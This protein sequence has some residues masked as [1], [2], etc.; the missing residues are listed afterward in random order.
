MSA[1]CCCTQQQAS[2][3]DLTIKIF[4]TS[5]YL[6][7]KL[8]SSLLLTAWSEFHIPFECVKLIYTCAIIVQKVDN[9]I[10]WLNLVSRITSLEPG[11]ALG[12]NG[13]KI[14]VGEKKKIGKWSQTRGSLGCWEG[15]CMPFSLPQTTA[16]LASLPHT[17]PIWP[18]FFTFFPHYRARSQ[19]IG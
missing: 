11:S 14:A 19:A 18:P 10:H 6:P 4:I 8:S 3:F 9:A 1:Y 17:F 12:E 2:S 7:Y 16:R 15:R 5:E 13:K